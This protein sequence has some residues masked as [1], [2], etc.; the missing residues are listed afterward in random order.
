MTQFSILLISIHK[1]R[2]YY[3]LKWAFYWIDH[4]RKFENYDKADFTEDE[5]KLPS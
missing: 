1:Q 4:V 3:N 2:I 5:R